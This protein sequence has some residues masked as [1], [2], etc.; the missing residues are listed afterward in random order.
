MASSRSSYASCRL[1]PNT[2]NRL[3]VFCIFP[4]YPICRNTFAAWYPLC[5]ST[6]IEATQ[7]AMCLWCGLQQCEGITVRVHEDRF[8][9][10]Q[11]FRRLSEK[12]DTA[13]KQC[14]VCF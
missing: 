14:F 13:C 1:S 4:H 2:D 3:T 7:H 6:N 8:H 11:L 9:A 12:G 10:I 5:S